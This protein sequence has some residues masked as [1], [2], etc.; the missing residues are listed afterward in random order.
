[1][2]IDLLARRWGGPDGG[3][4]G[5]SIAVSFLAWTL[6]ELGH[7]VRCYLPEGSA[8]PWKHPGARWVQSAQVV[9]P[10]DWT[11]DLVITTI[12]PAW[13][14]TT[15]AA[16]EGRAQR[17]LVYWH[18][19]G[20][21]PHGYGCILA[22]VADTGEP[23]QGWSREIILPPSSWAAQGGEMAGHSIVVPGAARAKGG[24]IS[25]AVA[26]LMTD[27]PWYVLP[28]RASEADLAP[29]RALPHVVVAPPLLSP[30]TWLAQARLV[31]SPTQAETYGL[32]M[33]EAATRGVPVVTSD[34]PGPR[35]ALRGAA[36][37]L[38]PE[39]PAKAWAEAVRAALGRPPARLE[40]PA[41]SE[42]ARSALGLRA[43]GP[44]PS[45]PAVCPA[46]S[47]AALPSVDQGPIVT[48]SMSYFG[49]PTTVA[50]A[51]ES[52]LGQ[53]ERRLR[54]VVVNDGADPA[55]AWEPLAHVVD[56]RLVRLDL[57]ANR[58]TYHA[59]AVTLA[60]CDTPWWLPHD[61]D[62]WSD[63]GRLA[64][65]LAAADG[66]DFV[67]GTTLLHDGGTT[68]E[69][70]APREGRTPRPSG[71]DHPAHWSGLWRTSWLRSVGGPSP[72]FRI[73]YDSV[74]V[75][76]ACACGRV[77]S[78]PGAVYHREMRD[79][80]LWHAE[81]TR[82]GSPA[83]A[84]AWARALELIGRARAVHAE[85]GDVGAL[86]AEQAV[87]EIR[88]EVERLAAGLRPQIRRLPLC[89]VAIPTHQRPD[90]CLDI[91]RDLAEQTIADGLTVT[92]YQDG[93]DADYSAARA[94]VIARGW[95]W[96]RHDEAGGKR[97]YWSRMNRVWAD[98][99]AAP[100]P[101]LVYLADDLRLTPRGLE[102]LLSE[103]ASIPDAKRGFLNPL[104]DASRAGKPCWTKLAARAVGTVDQVGWNDCIYLTSPSALAVLGW[105]LQPI[106]PNRWVK[107]PLL[108]SG[109]GEQIS[110]RMVEA[111]WSLWQVGR[112]LVDH[113]G[114]ESMMNPS[115]RATHPL[116]ALGFGPVRASLASIP[117]RAGALRQVVA[118][119]L[120][121]VDEL[122]VY[123]NGYPDVPSF[124]LQPRI[125]VARS[126]DHGDRG[127]AGKF[128]WAE[129]DAAGPPA[130]CF[131][132]DDDLVYPLDYVRSLVDA[133]ERHGRRAAV[134]V[135]GAV[136]AQHIVS[137]YRSRTQ[138]HCLQEVAVDTPVHVLGTGA[139]CYHSST[140]RVRREDFR[141]PNMADIWFALA[142]QR[143]KVPCIVAAHRA[144]WLRDIGGDIGPGI[145]RDSARRSGSPADTGDIQTR[146]VRAW[147]W[148]LYPA[149]RGDP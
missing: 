125:T 73:G 9:V 94:F 64:A 128:F 5:M 52:V 123:L 122:R 30:E 137:Y 80:S 13:R 104:R 46:P 95:R 121:Q 76:L 48:V 45:V 98:W 132:C 25:L 85:G 47:A 71:I 89:S 87:P 11:A 29:W 117:T 50:R 120:P 24:L 55:E 130:W 8:P 127:D 20:A 90:G 134:S 147:S 100:S 139:L 58:G 124:L 113:V 92:V 142:T 129:E 83:R 72:D 4:D 65:L 140:V 49:T 34:L 102:Q 38:P 26:R 111:G 66:A 60:A 136:L 99:R 33:V 75:T 88:A 53:T 101:H 51:V 96:V 118:S 91:L 68:R 12:A 107:A 133:A 7:S 79:G 56:P 77:R 110:R 14:R 106:D 144:G 17:R 145:Y 112:S 57:P 105:A 54:L 103:W 19:H 108:S 109:V 6:A 32:A 21:I 10:D 61:S 78:A 115:E 82:R 114:H 143:Q 149:D 63:P 146:T 116:R 67:A 18:H 62:D 69:E 93:G 35:F 44:R 70:P 1:M 141:A 31:F 126:Q 135:H 148:R 119:L 59:H 131:T 42:V 27:V 2:R 74:L 81:A 3:R 40:L 28:G 43:P 39:A 86:V 41:Y 22:R 23:V 15:L 84:E 37:Y 138:L 16:G 97:L 36:A